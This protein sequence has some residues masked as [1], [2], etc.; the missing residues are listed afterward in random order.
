MRRLASFNSEASLQEQVA[1]YIRLKRPAAIFM[2]DMAAGMKLTMGQAMKRKKINSS[3]ALPDLVVLMPVGDY[4]GLC[5][6]LK[7]E[8]V[9][10]YKK[11]GTI[12]ADEHLQEQAEMLQRLEN[13]GYDAKFACGF[14]QAQA[15]IDE[16][17]ARNL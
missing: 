4:H 9:T 15:V 11:D 14:D 13:L 7:K 17:F 6:E 16:Y 1:Q 12:R 5:I 2:S 8:G 3:R 10:V